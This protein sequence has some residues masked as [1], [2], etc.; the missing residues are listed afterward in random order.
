MQSSHVTSSTKIMPEESFSTTKSYKRQLPGH[1]SGRGLSEA[2][3]LMYCVRS[4]QSSPFCCQRIF[5]VVVLKCFL[6]KMSNAFSE[7]F[8]QGRVLFLLT[9]QNISLFFY[10]FYKFVFLLSIFFGSAAT[11]HV[12][13]IL[14][15]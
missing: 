5:P 6:Q 3:D 4:G 1:Q 15:N 2:L 12:I 11:Q 7:R 10:T 14:I 13:S 8:L 9:K